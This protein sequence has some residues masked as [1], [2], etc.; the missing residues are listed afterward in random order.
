[1]KVR[2]GFVSNSSSSSFVVAFKKANNTCPHCGRSDPNL[3]DIIEALGDQESLSE[4]TKINC[5]G[6]AVIKDGVNL[7]CMEEDQLK[8][9]ESYLSQQE[10]EVAYID[11][12]YHDE[13]TMSVLD[14]LVK[15]GN[16]V[17]I[18]DYR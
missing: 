15:S 18:A 6:E 16:A 10:W 11:I 7:S 13:T 5:K 9:V 4:R 12:S 3:L 1:M 17:I 14:N 2:N 8:S